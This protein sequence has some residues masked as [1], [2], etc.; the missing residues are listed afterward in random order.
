M[1]QYFYITNYITN[2]YKKGKIIWKTCTHYLCLA[3]F[4][5]QKYEI[6]NTKNNFKALRIKIV[7][8]L[9]KLGLYEELLKK[10][11]TNNSEIKVSKLNAHNIEQSMISYI[12]KHSTL[13]EKQ[14]KTTSSTLMNTLKVLTITKTI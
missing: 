13:D 1:F 4:F 10:S 2:I 9:G 6:E 14:K 12:I 7:R 8:T 11:I 5:I 3:N